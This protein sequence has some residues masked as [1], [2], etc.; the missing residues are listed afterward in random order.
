MRVLE[1]YDGWERRWFEIFAVD[2]GEAGR[3]NGGEKEA[4]KFR[5]C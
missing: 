4:G 1:I 5:I 2:E 3:K